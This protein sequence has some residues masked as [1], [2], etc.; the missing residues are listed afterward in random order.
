MKRKTYVKFGLD[1]LMAITF[2]LLFN[3]RVLGG[4]TFHEIA[5]LALAVAF[6]TH[7]LLNI[8]W[9]KQ[10]TLRLFDRKLPG[11][12][13][14]CYL[15]NLLLLIAMA[16]IMVSGIVVSRVVFP[17]LNIGSERW[18][19]TVHIS[20]SFIV[21]GL[22]GIH[23]GLHWQWAVK[24][25]SNI[26]K[27]K[28]Q[29]WSGFAAKGAAVAILLFGAYE[30][31]ATHFI[32]RIAGSGVIFGIQPQLAQGKGFG[33]RPELAEGEAPPENFRHGF[34][35]ES[36]GEMPDGFRGGMKGSGEGGFGQSANVLGVI[37][38]YSGI[39]A[40]FVIITYYF[41][42]LRFRRKKK[43]VA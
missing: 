9:V 42:K 29:K 31:Y 28:P 27:R 13:R 19:E 38:T 21:L 15:L 39:M 5:G 23:V 20:L 33:A 24:V 26:W 14:F 6:L 30:M 43:A 37:A 7:I 25:W 10:V 17:N 16:I 22:V 4:L 36:N 40:V 35:K 41:G 34:A 12:T 1:I 18:F 32:S 8:N 2:V 3:K 11:K